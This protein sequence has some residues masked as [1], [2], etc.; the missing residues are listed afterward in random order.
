M[1]IAFRQKSHDG[2]PRGLNFLDKTAPIGDIAKGFVSFLSYPK[3]H[4]EIFF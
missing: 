1:S 4:L 3:A 2:K